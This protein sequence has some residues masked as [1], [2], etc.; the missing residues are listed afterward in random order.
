MSSNQIAEVMG[1]SGDHEM[2][3]AGDLNGRGSG[4]GFAQ[5]R[6]GTLHRRVTI[7]VP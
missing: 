3:S 2:G 6:V 4:Y 7:A 1:V 5:E